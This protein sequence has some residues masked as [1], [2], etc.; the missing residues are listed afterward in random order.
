MADGLGL[1]DFY[2][3]TIERIKAQG[4]D[5]SRLGMGALMWV[6]YAERPLGEDEL[7]HALAI[8][9]GSRDFNADNIPSMKTLISCCQ[10]LITVDKEASTVRLVHFTLKEY[11]SAHPD[12][13]SSPHSRIAEICLT[14]LN[15]QQVQALSADPPDDLDELELFLSYCSL[16]WGVHAKRELSDYGRSLALE[17][18]QEYDNHIS[19]MS[20][21]W[22]IDHPNTE[23]ESL[24]FLLGGLHCA[25]FFGIVE[26][27]AALIEM[28]G[29]STSE[30]YLMGDSSLA[31][32]ARN[33][34]DEV[35]KM[36]LGRGEVDP[37]EP[38]RYGQ[39]PLSYAAE[40]GNEEVVKIL[41]ER[42]EVSPDFQDDNGRTP[43]SHA[44]EGGC[45]KVVEILLERA[46]VNPEKPD[47]GGQTRLSYA[48]Q[49][50]RGEV[51]KIL[52]G[53]EEVNP[54][55]PDHGGRTPLSHAARRGRVEVV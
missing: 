1:E 42:E 29:Y 35:V 24:P 52:L 8:E 40:K 43:L 33:G 55:C 21:S 26:V 2:G 13:F 31:W 28:Q 3:A 5:K 36:L 39:T 34:H 37:D 38:N 11:L 48:A 47:N 23:F 27:A 30:K 17:L 32:A 19:T 4:G 54:D 15:S 44:A 41:L 7:C 10:G 16:Y 51:V 45:M 14:Y 22:H 6:S 18:L 25:S 9:L 20:L 46:D 12:I 53:R 49:E 50:G